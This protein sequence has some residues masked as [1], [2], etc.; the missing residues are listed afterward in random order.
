MTEFWKRPKFW[1]SAVLTAWLLYILYENFQLAPVEI[2]LIPF[3][4]TLQFKVSAII[5]GS[6]VL[7]IV[8]TLIV[9]WLWRRRSSKKASASATAPVSSTSTVA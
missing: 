2:H 6:I 7:G 4:A 8:A 9:Q 1:V 5:I 3:A